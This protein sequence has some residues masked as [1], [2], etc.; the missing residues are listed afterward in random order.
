MVFIFIS[1][2]CHI[3]K[4]ENIAKSNKNVLKTQLINIEIGSEKLIQNSECYAF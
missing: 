1:I 2:K 3:Y 4:S